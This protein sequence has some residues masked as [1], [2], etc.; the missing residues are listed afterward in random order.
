M[1]KKEIVEGLYGKE[2][3]APLFEKRIEI[4]MNKHQLL[5]NKDADA[6]FSASGRTEL[7]GN[8]TD[9]NLGKVVA[10]SISLDTVAAV[11][12]TDDFSV[13]FVSDGYNPIKVDLNNLDIVQS[14]QGKT[15]ALIRGIA[16]SFAKR[17]VKVGGFCANVISSVLRGSGLSSSASVEVLIASVFNNLYNGN[18]FSTTELAIIG[19][20]AENNYFGKPCGLMDQVACANGGVVGIDFLN[21]EK[22][23]ITPV[24]ADFSKWGY[25]LVITDVKANHADLTPDYAAIPSE[26]RAV[27]SYFGKKNL[28]ELSPSVFF[29]NIAQLRKKLNN[30]RAVLRA[31]HFFSETKRAGDMITALEKDDCTAYMELVRESGL[32]SFR[33]LQNIYSPS[34]PTLQA[35]AIALAD[36]ERLLGKNG[37][38]RVHGGGFAGTIQSYVPI[39]FE[40]EYIARTEKIFGKGCCTVLAIR[41]LPVMMLP[42]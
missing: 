30:D 28:G 4:L 6:V 12:K 2:V 15:D 18:K 9:H 10:A 33:Y 23:V 3:E 25:S 13:T 19:R 36:S 38:S 35:V 8:H 1:M 29:E 32:S 41:N 37:V 20:E 34:A 24:N 40:D 22:P 27:A 14:E 11:H 5:F 21:V 16:F 26:M 17:G 39:D 7:G 42:Y 31:Y